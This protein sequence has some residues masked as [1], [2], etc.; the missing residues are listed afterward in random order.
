M[1]QDVK[2]ML[3]ILEDSIKR[4]YSLLYWIKE[5]YPHDELRLLLATTKI[6]VLEGLRYNYYLEKITLK[7]EE[8]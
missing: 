8:E 4:E 2:K 3:E 7:D 1:N 6:R 5:S